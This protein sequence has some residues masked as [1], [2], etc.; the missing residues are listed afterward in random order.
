MSAGEMVGVGPGL[1]QPA[2]RTITQTEKTRMA[3]FL[4]ERIIRYS[5]NL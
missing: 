1:E 3:L 4:I 5:H 2:K